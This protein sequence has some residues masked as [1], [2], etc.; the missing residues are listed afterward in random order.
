MD[1]VIFFIV[2]IGWILFFLIF[3]IFG[4]AGGIASVTAFLMAHLVQVVLVLALIGLIVGL[5]GGFIKGNPFCCIG[6]A[7]TTPCT[8]LFPITVAIPYYKHLFAGDGILDAFFDIFVALFMGVVLIGIW[9]I[10]AAGTFLAAFGAGDID[11]EESP[12][13]ARPLLSGIV[14]AALQVGA[15]VLLYYWW[16]Q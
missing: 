16:C 13:I 12:N 9:M 10:F 4:I 5:I 8:A 7:L 14:I 2:D 11:D 1:I 3:F 15:T 6:S